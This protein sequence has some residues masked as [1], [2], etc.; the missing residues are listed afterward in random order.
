MRVESDPRQVRRAQRGEE[1]ARAQVVG[2][3]REVFRRALGK[4]GVLG[5]SQEDIIQDA[6]SVVL[7]KLP[8]FRWEAKFETWALAILFRVQQRHIQKEA[9]RRERTVLESEMSAQDGND[10]WE[11]DGRVGA[12]APPWGDPAASR[13]G[14]PEAESV[15][16]AL[17]EAL[18]DCLSHIALEMREVWVRHR[19]WGHEHHEIAQALEVNIATV[20][21]RIFR[22]DG[23]MRGCL[24]KRGFTAE[25]LGAGR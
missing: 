1:Q 8:E 3:C 19:I 9:T 24:E 13:E 4:R 5:E 15:R 12:A 21:T 23:K 6:T 10:P 2:E 7:C 11:R 20:G 17:R 14:S 22:V 18:A 16:S 25:L